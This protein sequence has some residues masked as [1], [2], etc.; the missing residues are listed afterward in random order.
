VAQEGNK[1]AGQ[2]KQQRDQLAA[3]DSIWALAYL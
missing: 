1:T 3:A 2:E